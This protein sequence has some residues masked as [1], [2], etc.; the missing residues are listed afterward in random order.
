MPHLILGAALLFAILWLFPYTF[1]CFVV[2][3]VNGLDIKK[4]FLC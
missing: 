3:H 2:L 4:D 1:R